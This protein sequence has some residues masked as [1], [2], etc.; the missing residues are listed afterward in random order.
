MLATQSKTAASLI[1][2]LRARAAEELVDQLTARAVFPNHV[3]FLASKPN[4]LLS[5]LHS[6]LISFFTTVSQVYD[7]A[8][9]IK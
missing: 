6:S 5:Y 9:N 1:V 4:T 7:F 8:Y 3:F 2:H